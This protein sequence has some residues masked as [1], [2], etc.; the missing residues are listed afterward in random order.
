VN[1]KNFET[2]FSV[3]EVDFVF[4]EFEGVVRIF[5]GLI[6]FSALFLDIGEFV[7]VV[8]KVI[9]LLN[10]FVVVVFGFDE[11]VGEEEDIAL[12]IDFAKYF[13]AIVIVDEGFVLI[14]GK[15]L[16]GFF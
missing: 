2:L 11:F 10:F 6:D 3:V 12:V 9:A 5:L 16:F 7:V 13:S 15:G 14:L 8:G 1:A 4:E